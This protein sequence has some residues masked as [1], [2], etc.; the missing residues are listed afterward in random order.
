VRTNRAATAIFREG[1][2]NPPAETLCI[3][4]HLTRFRETGYTETSWFDRQKIKMLTKKPPHPGGDRTGDQTLIRELNLSVISRASLANLT[5]LN[6]TTVSSLVKELIDCRLMR[7]VGLSSA[8]IGRPSRLLEINPHAGIIVIVMMVT[9]SAAELLWQ[10]TEHSHQY[11]L[12]E[13]ALASIR[14]AILS[15]PARTVA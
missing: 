2:A 15:N 6:K 10:Q 12:L 14:Q 7:E 11:Q 3:S 13:P 1:F 4:V 5:G 8:P 9:N